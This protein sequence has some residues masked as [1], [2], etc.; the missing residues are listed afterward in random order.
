MIKTPSQRL[1]PEQSRMHITANFVSGHAF[2]PVDKAAVA[3]SPVY[4]RPGT[5]AFVLCRWQGSWG[6]KSVSSVVEAK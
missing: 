6:F 4:R 2:I 1:F 5:N 3:L